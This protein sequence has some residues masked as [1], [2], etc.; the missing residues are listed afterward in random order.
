LP[1]KKICSLV[2][3]ILPELHVINTI[4]YVYI[5]YKWARGF[6]PALIHSAHFVSNASLRRA[7]KQ[8]L[9]YETEQNVELSTYLIERSAV[10][11][12]GGS[13]VIEK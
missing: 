3:L 13:D 11:T 9:K 8:F 7:V 2:K 10:K 4:N 5:E 6:N 12:S 1:I